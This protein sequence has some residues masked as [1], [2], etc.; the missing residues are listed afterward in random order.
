MTLGGYYKMAYRFTS[1]VAGTVRFVCDG[2]GL[3]EQDT[4]DVVAGE[5]EIVVRF[6][7]AKADGATIAA[8]LQLGALKPATGTQSAVG[9]KLVNPKGAR[10]W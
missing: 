5:N 3:Y 9:L 1:T 7:A 8:G 10:D 4:F 2:A 6:A